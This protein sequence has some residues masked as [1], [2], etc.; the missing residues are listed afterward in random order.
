MS[1]R[2]CHNNGFVGHGLRTKRWQFGQRPQH[3]RQVKLTAAD[4]LE[5][6]F[7]AAGVGI[8]L[9]TGIAALVFAHDA[10]RQTARH[11]SKMAQSQVARR[12]FGQRA[13][14]L[15]GVVGG[16]DDRFG[17]GQESAALSR[18]FDASTVAL[19]E[20]EPELALEAADLLAQRRLGDKQALRSSGKVELGGDHDEVPK[21]A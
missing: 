16:L 3:E 14:N 1:N 4:A 18:E 20:L 2:H 19:Q 12:P 5:V 11:G 6:L 17:L 15:S 8:D 7:Y 9:D 10:F 13:C 21:I